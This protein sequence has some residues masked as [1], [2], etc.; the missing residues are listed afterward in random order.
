M[1]NYVSIRTK[2]SISYGYEPLNLPC[3]NCCVHAMH[4]KFSDTDWQV[5]DAY[6]K[7]KMRSYLNH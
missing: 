7:K 6:I 5:S 1:Y 4:D 2:T 3:D